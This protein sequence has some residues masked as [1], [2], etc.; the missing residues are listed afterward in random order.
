M[1]NCSYEVHEDLIAMANVEA[2]DASNLKMVIQDCLFRCSLFLSN[3]C[4]QAY[5]GAANMASHLNGLATNIQQE[6]KGLFVHC[7]AHSVNSC[8]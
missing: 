1:V 7:A 5:D 4:G 3:C 8:L 6:P 2:T